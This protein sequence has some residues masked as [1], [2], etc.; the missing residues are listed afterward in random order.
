M[1]YR[2]LRQS[3][4]VE[5]HALQRLSLERA[6]SIPREAVVTV[7]ALAFVCM[8]VAALAGL[9]VGRA[10]R[11]PSPTAAGA[12]RTVTLGLAR[13]QVPP[14]WTAIQPAS[15]SLPGFDSTSTRAFRIENGLAEQAFVTLA[16]PA[17]RRLIPSSLRP[18]LRPPFGAP[19]PTSLAGYSAWWY[20]SVATARPNVVMELTVLPTSAGVLAVACTSRST[21]A[22]PM[23]C[24]QEIAQIS[25][26]PAHVLRPTPGAAFRSAM[27][28]VLTRL[29]DHRAALERELNAARDAGAQAQVL[30]ALGKAYAA[31][32]RGLGFLAP[33][34]GREAVLVA[35]LH[36]AANAYRAA[37][38]AANIG[39]FGDYFVARAAVAAAESRVAK[40]LAHVG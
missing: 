40:A 19:I 15:A 18:A 35:S 31:A 6:A 32:A 39:A 1:T 37:G 30:Q 16:P 33:H 3:L 26:S 13:L 7:A 21:V 4:S 23:D 38:M 17:D 29:R 5:L 22:D 24:D 2:D 14:T 9:G 20:S 34:Q 12:S 8:I 25:V 36:N 27:P 10:L 28:A 11:S